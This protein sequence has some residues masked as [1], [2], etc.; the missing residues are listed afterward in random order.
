MTVYL[1]I[2]ELLNEDMVK[3]TH[4]RQA[5]KGVRHVN[6]ITMIEN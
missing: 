3:S 5:S 2:T 4:N 1:H 6:D